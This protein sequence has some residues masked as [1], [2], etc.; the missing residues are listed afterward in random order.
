MK[1][2]RKTTTNDKIGNAVI[3]SIVLLRFAWLPVIQ[4]IQARVSGRPVDRFPLIGLDNGITDL[5]YVL[6]DSGF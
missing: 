3:H 5:P 4:L 2:G 6:Q 1:N